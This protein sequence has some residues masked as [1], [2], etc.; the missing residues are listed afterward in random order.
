M[1]IAQSNRREQNLFGEVFDKF[2]KRE[3]ANKF[4]DSEEGK[5]LIKFS[6]QSLK[7]V[8][9]ETSNKIKK[10]KKD[11]EKIMK[12]ATGLNPRGA[13]ERAKREAKDDTGNQWY[14][15]EQ[16][17]RAE[18]MDHQE[19]RDAL[20]GATVLSPCDDDW[21]SFVDFAKDYMLELGVEKWIFIHHIERRNNA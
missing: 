17:I 10:A 9:K 6:E 12:C 1:G 8:D 20:K 11:V 2:N 18:I 4:L 19:Y 5:A 16:D 14:T 7:G 3:D 21:S 13:K 15:R